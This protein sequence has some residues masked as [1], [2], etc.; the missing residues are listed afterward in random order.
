[1]KILIV[2]TSAIGDVIQTLPVLDYLRNRFPCA[3]IDWVVEVASQSLLKAHPRLNHVL[4]IDTKRWRAPLR[5]WSTIRS[6]VSSIKALRKTKYDLI[7]DL[8]GNLK[9]AAVTLLAKGTVKVG[10]D[11]RGVR[12][13]GNLLATNHKI[14]VDSDLTIQE[15]YL[16]LVQT[17][18]GTHEPLCSS[19]VKFT[20]TAQESQRLAS[21]LQEAVLAKRPRIMVCFGSKW[22]NKQLR[23]STL[24]TLLEKIADAYDPSYLFIFGSAEEEKIANRLHHLFSSR[25]HVCGGMSLPLWQV[26]MGE[27]DLVFSVDSAALHLCATTKTPS[28]SVFGPTQA[29]IYK[30]VG[31]Q[32]HFIQ[33]PCPY[34]RTVLPRCPL[35]RSC[36]TG[37]CIQELSAETL[38]HR[39]K[40]S[41]KF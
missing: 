27:S 23:E 14:A 25:S 41:L 17:Y 34:G 11:R 19:G 15:R 28:F 13:K 31:A 9:S 33:G 36:P 30:P 29:S 12:E 8:Q 3:R 16:S 6:I 38:F 18:F 40:A 37:A 4:T 35:L 1:M 32:H 5:M 26:L 20:L 21:I 39:F 7:F 22:K 24:V 2:K 10:F